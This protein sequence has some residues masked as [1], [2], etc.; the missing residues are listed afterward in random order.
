MFRNI[1]VHNIPVRRT[2][3]LRVFGKFLT[4]H[5]TA[6]YLLKT[7]AKRALSRCCKIK[8]SCFIDEYF[9]IKIFCSRHGGLAE[10]CL[11]YLH[12]ILSV[13]IPWVFL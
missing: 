4:E 3:V 6:S 7:W 1:P 2:I 10:L 8:F 13:P 12:T 11:Y 9:K 5:P